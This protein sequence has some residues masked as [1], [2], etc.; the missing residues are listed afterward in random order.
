[1]S[2]RKIERNGRWSLKSNTGTHRPNSVAEQGLPHQKRMQLNKLAHKK[3]FGTWNV[4][5]TTGRGRAIAFLMKIRHVDILCVQ[6]TRRSGNK[7]KEMREV[8]KLMN[9]GSM[10][11]GNEIGIILSR[12]LKDSV[13]EVNRNNDRNMWLRLALT[14]FTISVSSVYV[15]QSGCYGSYRNTNMKWN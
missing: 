2:L 12:D 4:G 14:D 3:I 15:L 13:I 9:I 1:M 8:F 5:S 11:R 10:I 6:D 7:A